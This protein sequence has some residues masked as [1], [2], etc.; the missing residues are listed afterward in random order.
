MGLQRRKIENLM[1]DYLDLLLRWNYSF[2]LAQTCLL[3]STGAGRRREM[4]GTPR[5]SQGLVLSFFSVNFEF[6]VDR[7]KY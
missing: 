7:A 4:W 3:V 6:T 2:T 1:E 5:S